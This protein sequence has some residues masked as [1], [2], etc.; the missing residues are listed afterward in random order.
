M[1][2]S[3]AKAKAE[4]KK[5]VAT[6]P[7]GYSYSLFAGQKQLQEISSTVGLY[8]TY[9]RILAQ[10]FILMT[11]ATL[12]AIALNWQQSGERVPEEIPDLAGLLSLWEKTTASVYEPQSS[13][14]FNHLFFAGDVCFPMLFR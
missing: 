6:T 5:L 9:V 8:F 4:A 13:G 12:P 2:L 10:V 7:G 1:A 3:R 11:I 14:T